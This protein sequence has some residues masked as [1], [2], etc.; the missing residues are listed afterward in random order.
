MSIRYTFKVSIRIHT[1][2]TGQALLHVAIID[3]IDALISLNK[4]SLVRL[5]TL[6]YT[7]GKSFLYL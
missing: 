1:H 4:S 7:H 2:T 3:S 5:L 6:L